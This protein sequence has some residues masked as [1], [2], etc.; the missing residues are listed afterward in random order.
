MVVYSIVN[1]VPSSQLVPVN[2]AIYTTNFIARY[3]VTYVH[4][5]MVFSLATHSH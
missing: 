4:V 3:K 5:R 2:E 1:L